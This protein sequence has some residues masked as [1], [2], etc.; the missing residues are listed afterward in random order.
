ME[1][2]SPILNNLRVG[3]DRHFRNGLKMA[4]TM[5]DLICTTVPSATAENIYGWLGD[6][7]N[8][9][10]WIGPRAISN[11][12]EKDYRI[13]NKDFQVAVRVNRNHIRDDTLGQYKMKF[14][15]MGR[16]TT[17]HPEMLVWGGLKAG[18][19]TNCY[20]GQ[21][22]FDTDHPVILEDGSMGTFRNTDGGAGT[23]WFLVCSQ[24]PIKPMIFQERDKPQFT[25][26]DRPEDHHVF[27]NKEFVYGVEARYNCGYGFP[28]MA[29]GSKQTLDA[30]NF[31]IAWEELSS[32]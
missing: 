3:F 18:F 7:P 8:M 4:P 20:D 2:T 32:L 26:L 22:F 15:M 12:I 31:Q 27:M 28:Q 24:G 11:L 1:I 13:P 19:S 6:V 9:T 23:P 14:E 29:W 5:R 10:E 25:A 16:S 21:F 30:A 17:A